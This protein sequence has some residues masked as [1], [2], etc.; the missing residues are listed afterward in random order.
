M[1]RAVAALLALAPLVASA[2]PVDPAL[3]GGSPSARARIEE[4]GSNVEESFKQA[5]ARYDAEIAAEPYRILGRIARCDFVESFPIEYEYVTFSDETYA[6]AEQC[7]DDLLLQF[8]DHPEV[9]LRQLSRIYDDEEALQAA[10]QLLDVVDMHG[11][12]MGQRA[13]LYTELAAS[14]E[15]LDTEGRFRERTAG[16]AR[17]ALDHDVRAD[18][19]LI[20]AAYYLDN[21]DRKAALEALTSPFDGHDLEDGWYIVRKMAYLAELGAR[22]AVVALHARLDGAAYYDRTEAS[23]A[24][25]T[26]GELELSRRVLEDDESSFYGTERERFL[27]ALESGSAE[28]AHAAYEL[29]RDQGYWEDPIGI[30]R[31]ALFVDHPELPWRA[32]D[33]LGLLGALVFAAVSV[34]AWGLPLGLVHYRGL[35][36]RVNGKTLGPAGG[37][38]LREAWLGLAAL[39]T[40]GFIALYTIGPF[41]AFN[42][43]VAPLEIVAEQS[44]LATLLL[45]ESLLGIV[46]L[47]PVVY[48]LRRHFARWWATDWS[49]GKCVLIGV[50]G[51]LIFRLPLLA[52]VLSGFDRD[53]ALRVDN[54]MWQ[55]LIEVD[56]VYGPAA[57]I[58][59]LSFA[60]P[61]GEELLFRGLLLRACLRHV[62]FPVANGVQ[63][64]LFAA[65]H[66]DLAALPFLFAFGLA[67]GWL[68]R[69][70]G[71]LLAPMVMHAT[72]NLL[73]GLLITA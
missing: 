49:I 41:D 47:V 69:R 29:W 31:F 61:V 58:W 14:S 65:I 27:L 67:A 57:A 3:F 8:P 15:R 2:Q 32:R 50:A 45:V 68:A 40:S 38:R 52:M 43:P 12:T 46:F 59:I 7:E 13:R 28:E 25:R 33:A 24:L 54:A 10:Q 60:A 16:Y 11:W 70:T 53:A 42:D 66:F 36:N 21:G 20:L 30:N 18:V 34:L 72:M 23:A 37:L 64:L 73:A 1:T 5:L 17:R 48:L 71:G 35:V 55:M 6:L 4:I 62:S 19:R 9:R 51:A 44:Q 63:A 39:A 56:D 26:V 22:D